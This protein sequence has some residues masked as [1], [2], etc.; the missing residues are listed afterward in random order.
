M[1]TDLKTESHLLDLERLGAFLVLLQLLCAL[2]IEF[3][4]IEDFRYRWVRFGADFDQVETL[5]FGKL[6]RFLLTENTK[7]TTVFVDDAEA[8]CPNLVVQ[9]VGFADTAT[10]Y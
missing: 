6:K 10:P 8:G 5:L 7:L 9:A 3:P 4:P 1:I 2:V